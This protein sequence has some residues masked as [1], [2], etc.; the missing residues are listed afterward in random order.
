[1]GHNITRSRRASKITI[2]EK[3]HPLAKAVFAEMKRQCVT[4][5]ELEWRSGVLRS[6]FKAWRTDNR[7]GLDTI[8]AALGSL[9]WHVLAVPKAETLPVELRAD[10]EA[11][12]VKHCTALPCLH[13]IAAAAGRL[14]IATIDSR[15]R[16]KGSRSG[17]GTLLRHRLGKNQPQRQLAGHEIPIR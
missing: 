10:L 13:F 7:P 16:C 15:E 3:C 4:Y 17:I 5:E 9:G 1:M 11:I 12:A 14:P 2:P 6:T 8:E